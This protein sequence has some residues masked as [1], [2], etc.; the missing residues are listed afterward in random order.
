MSAQWRVRY[1]VMERSI[2]AEKSEESLDNTLRL[3][4]QPHL[5]FTSHIEY[6]MLMLS[7]Y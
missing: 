1:S 6:Q 3:E 4:N 2:Q 7:V 5:F